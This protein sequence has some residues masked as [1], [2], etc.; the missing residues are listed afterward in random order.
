MR[1][2]QYIAH[3]S[4]Y[5]RREADKLIQEGKVSINKRIIQDFSY[6][7][8][9][10]KVYVNDRLLK[11]K[12]EYTVIVYNK[13]KGELVSKKDDRG[14]KTIFDSLPKRFMHFTT[15]GRL[16]FSSEGLL[17]LSDNI[18]VATKLMESRLERVYLLKFSGFIKE[19]VFDAMESG[20]SLEDATKGGHLKSSIQSMEFS[21]FLGYE[22]IKNTKN[23][24]KLK[25]IINEGKNRELRRFF[26]H[27]GLEILDLKRLAY[28]FVSLNNLPSGKVR[29]LT[30]GEYNKLHQFLQE[31]LEAKY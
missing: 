7:V 9:N 23:F 1:L 2:N 10:Q 18:S 17:L 12:E 26:S 27:F 3:H 16:D 24:S 19:R 20:L 21:P 6:Q 13:P 11:E 4:K 25:V 8:K 22:V 28:G 15:I 30:R 29:F 14:R 31:G 5:S